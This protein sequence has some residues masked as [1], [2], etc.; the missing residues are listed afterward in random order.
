MRVGNR[1]VR[2]S[3]PDKIFFPQPGLTKGDLVRYYLDVAGCLLH[4]VRRRPMQMKRYP[5]GV[6][7]FFFYQKRVPEPP[8][9]TTA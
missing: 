1:E 9:M 8:A 7:G 2:I 5:D 3:N 6:D 4:H